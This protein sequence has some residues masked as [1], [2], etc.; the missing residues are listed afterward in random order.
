[1]RRVLVIGSGGSGKS[2]LAVRLAERT[3]LPLI[4][5]DA[6][7]WKP[8]WAES[9]KAEWAEKVAQLTSGAQWIMDGNY[10]GTLDQ[11]LAA[12]D[13]AIFLDLPRTL[14]LWRVVTRRVRFHGRARPDMVEGCPERLTWQFIGW[15]W[16]YPFERRPR[17]L[18]R[19]SSLRSDQRAI[20]LRSKS[21]VDAFL[22]SV[23]PVLPL[24]SA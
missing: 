6:L 10:G 3:G 16:R 13:T 22:E 2:R 11:R 4:H 14:C 24:Q 15:I 21:D 8:G 12:C 5:L 18:E 19:L 9:P 23:S 7:Y 17:I 1:M 20:V